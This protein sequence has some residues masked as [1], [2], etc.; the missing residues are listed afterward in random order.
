MR[1]LSDQ[2]S[3][4]AMIQARQYKGKK[5]DIEGKKHGSIMK[6]QALQGN[7]PSKSRFHIH[8]DQSI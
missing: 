6:T 2:K 4:D 1:K 8:H 3:D 5:K 7:I